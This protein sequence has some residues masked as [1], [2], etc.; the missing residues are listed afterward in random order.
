MRPAANTYRSTVSDTSACSRRQGT[1]RRRQNKKASHFTAPKCST[2]DAPRRKSKIDIEWESLEAS[3]RR[4]ATVDAD[5]RIERMMTEIAM[6]GTKG[7]SLVVNGLVDEAL[8]GRLAKDKAVI[9]KGG[10]IVC[11]Y[12]WWED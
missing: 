6:G 8:W 12:H 3:R 10:M 4:Y 1:A 2:V 11:G 5:I 7:T 9:P